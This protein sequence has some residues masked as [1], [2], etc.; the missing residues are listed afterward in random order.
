MLG[1]RGELEWGSGQNDFGA[2]NRKMKIEHFY[3][4]PL[5]GKR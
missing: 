4:F 5:G 1:E 2:H 3:T